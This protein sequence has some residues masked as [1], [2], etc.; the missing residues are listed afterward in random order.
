MKTNRIL[1]GPVAF[2]V[3]NQM[4]TNRSWRG[5]CVP[6]QAWCGCV[7][8]IAAAVLCAPARAADTTQT[9]SESGRLSLTLDQAIKMALE[10]NLEIQIQRYAPKIALH[11]LKGA[12]GAYDV[13]LGM[14]A[15]HNYQKS[16][17]TLLQGTIQIPG[18]E[19][20]SDSVSGSLSGLLPLGTRYSLSLSATDTD[21]TRYG[22]DTNLWQPV[23]IPYSVGRGSITLDITQPLL[24]NF[25]IDSA[26]LNIRVARNR[27]KY[28]ELAFRQQ[29]MSI[30]TSVEVAYYDLIAQREYVRVQEKAVELA[31][32]LLEENRR[33]VQI[34]AM[35]PLDEKQA[36]AQLA[37]AEADLITAQNNLAIQEHQ[38]K[39]LITDRYSELAELVLEPV[40]RLEAPVRVF[41]K[42]LSWTRA[43]SERPD[44]L[45]AKLDLERAG[46]QLKYDRNQLFPE[47]DVRVGGGYAGSTPEFSGVFSD[48]RHRDQPFYYFGGQVSFPL[49]NVSA[50]QNYR[51]SK[52]A[53]EQALLALKRMERDIMV[54]VDDA[55]NQARTSYQRVAATRKAR[56]YARD[57]LEAELK[58][59][60][61]GKTTTYTVLQLQRDLTAAMSNEIMALVNYNKALAQLSLVEGTT[62]ERLGINLEIE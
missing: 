47:L 59:L 6:L 30:V 46:I 16:G 28:S 48:I 21:G 22:F 58:K 13:N 37:S 1:T 50:R 26:R 18:Q 4:H 29:V 2:G 11:T 32:Q 14:S 39:K 61:T 62:L 3:R 36:E 38:L 8:A 25:W 40:E 15:Q 33:R 43:L 42:Q 17:S 51:A 10:K 41:D 57:A 60:E 52:L 45:Q 24:K 19:S 23:A 5:R 9:N 55:I 12:Y 31:R 27:L 35:T 54:A 53:V 7:I 56:E 49:G 20:E 34:G 44:Y